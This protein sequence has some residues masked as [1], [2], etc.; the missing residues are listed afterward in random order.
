MAQMAKNLSA[1]WETG[2]Q[3]LGWEDSPGEGTGNP[4]HYS[5]LENATD[6]GSL[7]SYSPW[8]AKELDMT[9]QLTVGA[10]VEGSVIV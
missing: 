6:R 9:E 10:G 5:C 8:D 3:S 4:L 2:V 1:M 7:A